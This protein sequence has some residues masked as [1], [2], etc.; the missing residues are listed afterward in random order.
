MPPAALAVHTLRFVLAYGSDAGA[1]LQ[2]TGH[3]YLH[4]LV[5]WIVLLLALAVGAFLSALGRAFTGRSPLPRY[6]VS[7][8]ALWLACSL[9]L[10]AIYTCQ[11]FLEGLFVAGHPAG[12]AGIFGYGGW[13]A[14]PAAV[15]IG[16]VLAA[17]LHGAHWVVR[18]VAAGWARRHSSRRRGPARPR[19]RPRDAFV[20]VVA[21]LAGGWSVRGPPM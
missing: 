16:L 15:F 7:L 9:S 17:V 2:R 11:E 6:T 13:W 8:T 19:L 18:A 20:P 14:I 1:D 12:L 4:S 10:V 5:P 21:P 3:S